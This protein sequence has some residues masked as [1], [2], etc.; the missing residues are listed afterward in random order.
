MPHKITYTAFAPFFVDGAKAT[1]THTFG[2]WLRSVVPIKSRR[3]VFSGAPGVETAAG[4]WKGSAHGRRVF[5]SFGWR[6]RKEAEPEDRT[7]KASKRGPV[8]C[9][10]CGGRLY[11]N[12]FGLGDYT[13]SLPRNEALF[14]Q[15]GNRAA[16][17]SG[18]PAYAIFGRPAAQGR[19]RPPGT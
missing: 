4:V 11:A 8:S 7:F 2:A 16:S 18:G 6:R 17:L 1:G 15:A 12:P 5:Q 19:A 9:P 13:A 14:H 3:V 10:Y